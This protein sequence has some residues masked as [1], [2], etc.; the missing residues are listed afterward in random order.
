MA[1]IKR[2]V[3]SGAGRDRGN[4]FFGTGTSEIK[5]PIS[6]ENL[7]VESVSK[8]DIFGTGPAE[9]DARVETV[10]AFHLSRNEVRRKRED[11]KI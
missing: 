2:A 1:T 8:K 3:W 7:S 6:E 4:D 11:N 10:T 5:R 9:P